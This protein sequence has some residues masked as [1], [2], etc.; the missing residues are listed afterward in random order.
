[1]FEAVEAAFDAVALLV[2]FTVVGPGLFSVASGRDDC[3]RAQALYLCDDLGGVIAL[4]G[5][6]RFGRLTFEQP[7]RLGILGG[8][9]CSDAEGDGQAILIG[10][11][12]DLGAQSTSGTPQSRVFGAP[13]LRPAAACWCA[14]TMVESSIR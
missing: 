4:V 8:L 14:R 9:A 5:D 12:M 11:Q 3:D 13:F 7:D 1:V 2:E 10:Q 6:D